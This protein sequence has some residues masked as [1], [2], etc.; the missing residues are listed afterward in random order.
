MPLWLRSPLLF[1]ATPAQG[2]VDYVLVAYL[3]FLAA[4]TAVSYTVEGAR[5]ARN[6]LAMTLLVSAVVVALIPLV[7]APAALVDLW[8][9]G[10][11]GSTRD[12]ALFGLFVPVTVVTVLLVAAFSSA[13]FG[14]ARL[15]DRYLF[16][17]I[18][19]WLVLFALWLARE[20]PA[21]PRLLGIGCA[22][23]VVLVATL[24]TRLL[25]RDTNLQ[26]DAV[27]SAIWSRIRELDPGRP[28]LLRLLLVLAVLAALG[29]IFVPQRRWLLLPVLIVFGV[30]AT[31]VWESRVH[32]A[33]LRVF[34]DNRPATWSWVDRIV[35][36]DPSVADV[37]VESGR[38]QLVNIG[39]FRWTEFFNARISHVFRIGVPETITTDGRSA[40][41]GAGRIVR[42]LDG[43]PVLVDYAVAPPGITLQGREVARGT[44][45]GLRL[46]RLDGPLRFVSTQLN[47]FFA[48]HLLA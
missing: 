29:S 2:V 4:Q 31:L 7:V 24:P 10:R 37:F 18:P 16:Y 41:I 30:N 34:A 15:H 46:W 43:K 33:D 38:C 17:V 32:D 28:G 11:S 27:A 47:F 23:G 48:N 14:G 19:L 22:V 9:R 44:L 45:A 39:A 6:R 26:F 13:S 36:E 5:A 40:I 21:S 1:A 42:T 8:R 25:L 20:A 35:T 3:V 12:A